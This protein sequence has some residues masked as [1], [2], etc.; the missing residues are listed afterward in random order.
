MKPSPMQ[1]FSEAECER[2]AGKWLIET[3]VEPDL[4]E[5]VCQDRQNESD[6]EKPLTFRMPTKN[7]GISTMASPPAAGF[8][9]WR[10]PT[11]ILFDSLRR[12]W[13]THRLEA[14]AYPSRRRVQRR[15]ST[16]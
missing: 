5:G 6:T 10:P 11:T 7:R 16:R 1:N 14:P 4:L 15:P 9:R 2:C 13:K 12:S 3:N 8:H